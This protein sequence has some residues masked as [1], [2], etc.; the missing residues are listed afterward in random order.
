MGS[1][2]TQSSAMAQYHCRHLRR[3]RQDVFWEYALL[4]YSDFLKNHFILYFLR[5]VAQ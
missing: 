5:E 4:I 2:C 1:Q 3:S